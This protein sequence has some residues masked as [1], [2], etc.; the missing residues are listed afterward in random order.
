MQTEKCTCTWYYIQS[1]RVCGKLST[2]M[3]NEWFFFAS[4]F[5][6]FDILQTSNSIRF[7]GTFSQLPSYSVNFFLCF[8]LSWFGLVSVFVSQFF[9]FFVFVSCSIRL[10]YLTMENW[11]F[12]VLEFEVNWKMNLWTWWHFGLVMIYSNLIRA[13]LCAV[14]AFN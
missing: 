7:L 10:Q 6:R 12:R 3:P 2:S 9:R 14:H 5:E 11:Y 8:V 4:A 1:H 13:M